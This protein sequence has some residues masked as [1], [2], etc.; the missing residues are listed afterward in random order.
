MTTDPVEL[1]RMFERALNA[2]DLGE[3]TATRSSR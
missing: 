3:V 1:D 2:G